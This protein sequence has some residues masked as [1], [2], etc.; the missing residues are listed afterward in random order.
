MPDYRVISS[1]NHVLEPVDMW[2]SRAEKSLK[3]L[4]PHVRRMEDGDWWYADG[5]RIMGT[6]V[7]QVGVRFEDRS[8]LKRAIS[9]EE[10]RPGGWIPEL[11]V[12]DMEDDGVDASVIFPTTGLLLYSMPDSDLLTE[13]FRIYNDWLAEFCKPFPDRLKGI[14]CINTDDIKSGVREL[15]GC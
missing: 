11:H 7:G 12:K 10:P 6:G 13:I 1:D 15:A 9:V 3:D 14:A 2:T 5:H 8:E 4:I